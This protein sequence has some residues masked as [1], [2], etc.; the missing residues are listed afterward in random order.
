[1][2]ER[3]IVDAEWA[4]TDW[5]LDKIIRRYRFWALF[6]TLFSVGVSYG[7]VMTHQVAFLVDLG[8]TAL[9]ASF[10]LF[11]YGIW[12]MGGQLCGF[13]SDM[14]GRELIYITGCG[15][16]V[17]AYIMLIFS[18]DV[19]KVW[20]LY[21]YA[22]CF[23]FFSGIIS[24]TYAAAAADIFIG[25]HFGATLGAINIGYGLGNS[26]GAWL[27]GSLFDASGSY[28][29]AFMLAMGMMILAAAF[30]WVSSP[31]KIRLAG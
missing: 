29:L 3:V 24:P 11:L 22:T 28:M 20:M 2:K 30:I 23:G 31:R 12:C 9:F 5:T 1:M 6:F 27:G 13:L 17:L 15:G 18:G 8:F 26:L 25:E 14:F 16:V 10:L 7:I 21:A 19:S 4:S